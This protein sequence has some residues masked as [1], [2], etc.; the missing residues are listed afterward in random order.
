MVKR[1][2][3]KK[4]FKLFTMFSLKLNS[5]EM[6]RESEGERKLTDCKSN[7]KNREFSQPFLVITDN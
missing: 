4:M 3:I 7:S 6:I 2:M 1:S 5:N